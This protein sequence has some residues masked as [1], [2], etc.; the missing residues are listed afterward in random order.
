[1]YAVVIDNWKGEG[2]AHRVFES[3]EEA[4]AA[5]HKVSAHP[6]TRGR[7]RVISLGRAI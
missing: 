2:T 4:T 7:V 6:E 1:M 3:V 5:M